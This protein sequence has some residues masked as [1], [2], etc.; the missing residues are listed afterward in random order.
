VL[1]AFAQTFAKQ[2][3]KPPEIRPADVDAQFRSL[4]APGQ[5]GHEELLGDAGQRDPQTGEDKAEQHQE[6][7]QPAQETGRG[8]LGGLIVDFW[9]RFV[10]SAARAD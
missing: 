2:G 1:F 8:S 5:H 10:R 4:Q 6:K 7:Q 3:I 9:G